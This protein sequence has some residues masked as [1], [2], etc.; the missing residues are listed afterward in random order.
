M[1]AKSKLL[2]APPFE[3]SEAL[4]DLGNN[5]RTARLSRN[6]TSEE[7]AQKLGIARQVVSQA[8]RGKASTSIVVYAGL[9]W[10][11]NLTHQLRAVAA[12]ESDLEGK[13]LA[14]SRQRG[15]RTRS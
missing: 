13:A 8:E 5:L 10:V 15:R 12:S 7:V 1:V 9:L 4:R 14:R 3:V 2:E 11:Y 6:F